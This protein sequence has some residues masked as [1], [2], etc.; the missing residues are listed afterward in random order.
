MHADFIL[1]MVGKYFSQIPRGRI[2]KSQY[3]IRWEVVVE[4]RTYE[5]ERERGQMPAGERGGERG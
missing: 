5:R 1:Y 3:L 4:W 2:Y